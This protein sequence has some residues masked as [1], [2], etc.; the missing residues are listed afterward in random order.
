LQ[1]FQTFAKTKVL[2]PKLFYI[3]KLKEMALRLGV[4]L[5]KAGIYSFGLIHWHLAL[6][7]VY[8]IFHFMEYLD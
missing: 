6:A 4:I 3:L 8:F 5:T 7:I 2:V 1:K